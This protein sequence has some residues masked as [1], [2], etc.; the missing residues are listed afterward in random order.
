MELDFVSILNKITESSQL[1][2]LINKS[3]NISSNCGKNNNSAIH[4]QCFAYMQQDTSN[5]Q[6]PIPQCQ[7]ALAN[8]IIQVLSLKPKLLD[9]TT[10]DSLVKYFKANNIKSSGLV[11]LN[12]LYTL[13]QT[14]FQLITWLKYE[15]LL[16]HLMKEQVYEPKTLTN[17]VLSIVKNELQPEIATKFSSAMNACVQ[18]CRE[19]NAGKIDDEEEEKWC[20]II[21]WVSWFV[22]TEENAFT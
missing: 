3:K 2:D 18:Y 13:Y 1:N 7:T 8:F 12:N 6:L 20:E 11:T 14:K 4:K 16:I 21:D 5:H 9:D 22:G 10:K 15:S 19:A 17:E